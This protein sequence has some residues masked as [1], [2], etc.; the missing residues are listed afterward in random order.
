[1]VQNIAIGILAL[2]VL[3][4]YAMVKGQANKLKRQKRRYDHLL[5]GQ[6]PDINME[7]LLVSINDQIEKSNMELRSLDRKSED[8]K[9]TS[10]GAVNKMGIV[11]YDSID[12]EKNDLSFSFCL[13]DSYLNGII[14]T[15]LYSK[16]GSNIYIKEIKKGQADKQLSDRE[17]ECLNKAKN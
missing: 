15:N 1:M 12:G 6:N 2:M 5:R 11:H 14:L 4:L 10:L 16:E 7:E 3:A 8:T 17:I 9:N 13:L